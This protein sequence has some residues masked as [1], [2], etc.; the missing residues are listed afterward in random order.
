[1]KALPF[2][3]RIWFLLVFLFLSF[4]QVAAQGYPM[5]HEQHYLS[6]RRTERDVVPTFVHGPLPYAAA[7]SIAL[8]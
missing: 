6:M 1:L 8:A 2:S 3:F 7:T 5:Q 4:L